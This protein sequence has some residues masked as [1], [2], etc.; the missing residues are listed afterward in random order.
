MTE[1]QLE[2]FVKRRFGMDLYEFIKNKVEEESLHDY[3]IANILNVRAAR[4]GRLR[5]GFGIKK[6]N[7]FPRRFDRTHGYGAVEIFKTMIENRD[8]SLSDL[9]R[10]F[11]FSRE[12][13]R[14]VYKKI[15]GYPYTEAYKQKRIE[16][17]I[18]RDAIRRKSKDKVA[19]LDVRERIQSL[20]LAVHM[21]NKGGFFRLFSNGYRFSLKR[22]EKPIIIGKKQYFRINPGKDGDKDCDFFICLCRNNEESTHFI[23]P[24]N[25]M[26]KSGISLFPEAGPD[27]SK[28]AQ[29]KE[30]WHLL[31]Y[32][33]SEKLA[34]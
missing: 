27:Q 24:R 23:I 7:G 8:I 18:N 30:A 6:I 34:S 31:T 19:L 20:G 12:Y 5:K 16:R 26:P 17:K 25:A 4:I 22:S 2:V 32:K 29:F 15:Y 1:K 13:A 3:E 10:Y 14:Q 9:A 21:S 33:D 11:G 28:Y